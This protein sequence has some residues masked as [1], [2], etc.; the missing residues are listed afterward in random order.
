MKQSLKR[1]I[2]SN[3]QADLV[4]VETA[5]KENLD[6]QLELVAQVAGHILFSGG[7]RLRP[8]L[9]VLG[10]RMCGFEGAAAAKAASM[11]EYLHAATLIHDDLIDGADTRRGQTAA[12]TIYGNE[13][14]VLTGDFLLARALA[15]AA[16][17]AIVELVRVIG[18][19]TE[20]MS[21]GE[22]DQLA[23]KGDV[24][25]KESD[26]M[27]VIHR[28]TAVLFRSACRA[29]ALL[30]GAP[31][32]RQDALADY[33]Y[34]LG[35]AFQMA[36]DLLDYTADGNELGKKVGADLREGKLTLP[37]IHAL[38]RATA[39]DRERMVAIIADT[40]FSTEAFAELVAYLTTY[41]GIDYTR[42]RAA[43]RVEQ[44]KAAL[45]P[46]TDSPTRQTLLDI[47]DYALV[48]RH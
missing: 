39:P 22:I 17:T 33:G 1:K 31:S 11:F 36:D 14:A 12:H 9:T 40:R 19:V 46:F 7:K 35:I 2:L 37:V 34:H 30:A 18:E 38:A 16:D 5:L 3:V 42:Q 44:A 32:N 4:A 26:Y 47:A 48:R 10:A 41:G 29:G 20:Q 25:L 45:A 21:L 23:R 24:T 43:E 6:P 8:L 27:A 28:K 15:I 13:I